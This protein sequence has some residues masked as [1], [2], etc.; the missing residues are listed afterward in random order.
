[1]SS[2]KPSAVLLFRVRHYVETAWGGHRT[3]ED[4]S[5]ALNVDASDAQAA[6]IELWERGNVARDDKHIEEFYAW[7]REAGH[8]LHKD[9]RKP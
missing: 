3:A 9:W 7:P 6:L 1:M 5:E 4:V 8:G 2:R